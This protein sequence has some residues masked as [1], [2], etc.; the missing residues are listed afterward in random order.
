MI[1]AEEL[2]E[3]LIFTPSIDNSEIIFESVK[4]RQ[5]KF[6]VSK[7]T[8]WDKRIFRVDDIWDIPVVGAEVDGMHDTAQIAQDELQNSDTGKY[9]LD[10]L[11]Q[12]GAHDNFFRYPIIFSP[13][14][15]VEN[16][17]EG[18]VI[19]WLTA[20]K[21]AKLFP[22]IPLR[23]MPNVIND[24]QK[25]FQQL[26][27]D[28][29]ELHQESELDS[30]GDIL[31]AAI[32]GENFPPILQQRAY[33]LY[34]QRLELTRII[35]GIWTKAVQEDDDELLLGV[36]QKMLKILEI[37]LPFAQARTIVELSIGIREMFKDS[38]Q[39]YFRD[40]ELSQLFGQP[41]TMIPASPL[42]REVYGQ[43]INEFARED[44]F[45]DPIGL[46]LGQKLIDVLESTDQE[47]NVLDKRTARWIMG[48]F[49]SLY[50]N[51]YLNGGVEAELAR[52]Y[53][54]PVITV[55][56]KKFKENN[57]DSEFEEIKKEMY[58]YWYQLFEALWGNELE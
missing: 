32:P 24:L 36:K 50:F 58:T 22:K 1:K 31:N 15:S 47:N 21:M 43:E 49:Y 25:K 27:Q 16:I 38:T 54:E 46:E 9:S 28:V 7:E 14:N 37:E 19:V 2:S 23:I 41:T 4:Q 12:R 48:I 11:K 18:G 10:I 30:N 51:I 13:N 29:I 44:V 17:F 6:S 20:T 55:L 8:K 40:L 52:K 56:E 26:K 34:E 35:Y 3:E 33:E 45:S 53:I 42:I 57:L 39:R 5:D